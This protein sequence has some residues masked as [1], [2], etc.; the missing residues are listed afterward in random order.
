VTIDNDEEILVEP[1]PVPT[2]TAPALADTDQDVA[3]D[4][5]GEDF[6]AALAD[7]LDS[8]KEEQPN[9]Q[10]AEESAESVD[11]DL[12]DFFKNFD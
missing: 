2:E 7:T 11:A 8:D 12:N 5:T 9:P 1:T 4:D 10:Q 6:L 3:A